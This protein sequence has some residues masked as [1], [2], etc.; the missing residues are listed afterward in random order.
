MSSTAAAPPA[1]LPVIRPVRAGIYLLVAFVVFLALA[2][3]IFIAFAFATPDAD[4][5]APPSRVAAAYYPNFEDIVTDEP[6][7]PAMR[8]LFPT[9]DAVPTAFDFGYSGRAADVVTAGVG[10]PYGLYTTT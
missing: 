8:A 2:L 1:P 4:Y 10:Y 7:R 9:P 5:Q 3:V 6:Q